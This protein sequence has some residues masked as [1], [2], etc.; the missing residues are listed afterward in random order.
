MHRCATFKPVLLLQMCPGK[1]GSGTPLRRSICWSTS[2][3]RSEGR[4][5]TSPGPKTARESPWWGRAERS[6]RPIWIL[7]A[8]GRCHTEIW[9]NIVVCSGSGLC[10][11]GTRVP[12]WVKSWVTVRSSTALTSSRRGRIVLWQAATT[13][14]PLSWRDRPLNIKAPQAWVSHTSG[15]NKQNESKREK[16]YTVCCD[17]TRLTD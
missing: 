16:H 7:G 5:R 17:S 15:E 14:A 6:E 11:S 13:T 2:I 12:R 9:L 8:C 4:S 3:S 1:S 10:F